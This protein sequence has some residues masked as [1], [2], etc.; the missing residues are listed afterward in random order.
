MT[1]NCEQLPACPRLPTGIHYQL[2]MFRSPLQSI[3]IRI[4]YQTHHTP[5][6][7][8]THTHT[9]EQHHK[10]HDIELNC[11]PVSGSISQ[12]HRQTGPSIPLAFGPQHHPPTTPHDNFS[13]RLCFCLPC[14]TIADPAPLYVHEWRLQASYLLFSFLQQIV[15]HTTNSTTSHQF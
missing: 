5:K 14:R 12:H 6:H 1:C 13:P 15:L 9:L 2:P 4:S 11:H 8:H 10:P 7:T 3:V